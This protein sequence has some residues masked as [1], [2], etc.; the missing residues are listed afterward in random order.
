MHTHVLGSLAGGIE[1]NR[2]VLP[3]CLVN[4]FVNSEAQKLCCTHKL[5][6]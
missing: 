6:L 2:R 5:Y 3:V 4:I 1:T